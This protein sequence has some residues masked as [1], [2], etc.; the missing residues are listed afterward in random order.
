MYHAEKK[1]WWYKILHGQVLKALAKNFGDKQIQIVD[2]GCGTGG[3]MDFLKENA[4]GNIR[5]FDISVHALKL[6]KERG[7][8]VFSGDIRNI[9]GLFSDN[10]ADAFI[11]NDSLY[12]LS[13]EER[14]KFSENVCRKLKPKGVVILNLPAFNAFRGT[15]DISV[16]I[17]NRFTKKN[18][19]AIFDQNKFEILE[20]KYWPFFLSPLIFIVRIMQRIKIFFSPAASQNSDVTVPPAFINNSFFAI[21]MIENK[22]T[23]YKPWGSSL[24]VVLRKK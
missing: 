18:I 1:L 15:H 6:S 24:F 10:S 9:G 14:K 23:E 5:G 17:K 7:L 20:M 3:L 19:S 12:F 8:D 2:G 21:T 16:G 13:D 11:S 4:Y 22:I